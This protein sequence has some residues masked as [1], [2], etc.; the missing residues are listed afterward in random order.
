MQNIVKLKDLRE[1]MQRY[2]NKVRQGEAFIVFKR[3]DPLFKIVPIADDEW[4]EVIDFTKIKK[5]GIDIDEVLNR[6]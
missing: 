3:S 4:E 1:N 6:L 2:A 5:G